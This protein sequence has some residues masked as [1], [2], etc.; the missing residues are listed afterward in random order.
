MG[1]GLGFAQHGPVAQPPVMRHVRR[2][3][4]QRVGQQRRS[5]RGAF[6]QREL[7]EIQPLL[8]AAV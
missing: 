2:G 3:E 5:K 1:D 7:R 4:G 8:T 6:T